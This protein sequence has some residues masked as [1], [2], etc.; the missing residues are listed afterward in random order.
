[1]ISAVFASMIVAEQYFSLDSMTARSTCLRVEAAACHGVDQVDAGE[2]PGFLGR[3]LRLGRHDA[4]GDR[5][6]G[7]FSG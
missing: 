2:D 3:A 4:I 6:R 1:M 5:L 7:L